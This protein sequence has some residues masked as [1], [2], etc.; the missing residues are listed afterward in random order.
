MDFRVPRIGLRLGAEGLSLS[1]SETR[2][3]SFDT[4]LRTDR[5]AGEAEIVLNRFLSA[6]VAVVR[7]GGPGFVRDASEGVAFETGATVEVLVVVGLLTL[8]R[9]LVGLFESPLDVTLVEFEVLLIGA[10]PVAREVVVR[11]VAAV[12]AID[13]LLGRADMPSRLDS[14]PEVLL[15]TDATDGRVL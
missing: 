7:K 14:S 2:P 8:V 10:G 9:V 13:I 15:S 1:L 11:S 12:G 3:A 4:L 5:A 6:A